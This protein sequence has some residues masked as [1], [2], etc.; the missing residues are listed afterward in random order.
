MSRDLVIG[1]DSSTSATK[2]IAWDRQGRVVAEGRAAIAMSNPHPGWFEQDPGEWWGSTV[3]AL[4]QVTAK[5]DAELMRECQGDQIHVTAALDVFLHRAGKIAL[6]RRADTAA[7]HR[8]CLHV[9]ACRRAVQSRALGRRLRH[10]VDMVGGVCHAAIAP[11]RRVLQ[12][13]RPV[14]IE[15][16]AARAALQCVLERLANHV[17][18]QRHAMRPRV[19]EIRGFR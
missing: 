18:R 17:R 3:A 13:R 9:F 7:A 12:R 4:Q 8:A 10:H 1:I 5:I 19:I 6:A 16:D 14:R 2:A 11:A 15:Q